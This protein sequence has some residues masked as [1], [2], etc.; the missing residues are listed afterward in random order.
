MV[1]MMT[2]QTLFRKAIADDTRYAI[3]QHLCCV[4]LNVS[5]VVDKLDGKVKQPTVSH[6]LKE[7]E[8]MDLVTVRQEGRQRYYTLNQSHV[9]FCCGQLFT[10]FKLDG[11]SNMVALD[12]I[13][14]EKGC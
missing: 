4:W 14:I 7:L 9:S 13:T 10:A 8:E 3:M 2:D 5:D 6:H 1:T 11:G 12:D